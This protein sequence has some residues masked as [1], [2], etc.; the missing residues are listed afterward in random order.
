MSLLREALYKKSE[1]RCYARVA[2]RDREGRDKSMQL[3][4][5]V[6]LSPVDR[7]FQT[8]VPRRSN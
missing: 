2:S 5:H 7:V 3:L 4:C 6:L 1:G 8:P